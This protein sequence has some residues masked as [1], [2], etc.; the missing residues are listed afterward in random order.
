MPLLFAAGAGGIAGFAVGRGADGLSNTLKWVAVL[1]G[2]YVGAK[3]F[4]VI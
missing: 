3:A 2:L 1:G 4:K